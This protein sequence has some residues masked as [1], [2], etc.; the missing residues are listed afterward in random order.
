M[1]D[2][3]TERSTGVRAILA[4]TVVRSACSLLYE[5]LIAQTMSMMAGNTVVWYSLTVGGY[6]GA[7]GLGAVLVNTRATRSNWNMLFVVELLL[8][9]MGA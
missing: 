8:S 1:A 7:M 4:I 6:L 9:I 5:L 3:M 2:S